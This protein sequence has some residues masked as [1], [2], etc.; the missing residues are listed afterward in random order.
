V[1]QIGYGK[2]QTP[3]LSMVPDVA[4]D[5]G[6]GVVPWKVDPDDQPSALRTDRHSRIVTLDLHGYLGPLGISVV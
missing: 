3:S 4:L 2:F 1:I 6:L 5:D